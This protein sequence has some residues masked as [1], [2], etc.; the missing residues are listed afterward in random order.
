MLE[1]ATQK[2]MPSTLG[3]QQHLLTVAPSE[4]WLSLVSLM[5]KGMMVLEVMMETQTSVDVGLLWCQSQ[6]GNA[7]LM[8]EPNTSRLLSHG[9]PRERVDKQPTNVLLVLYIRDAKHSHSQP[10]YG[11]QE[12]KAPTSIPHCNQA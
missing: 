6:P 7:K 12:R 3:L 5:V 1:Y 11:L 9:V 4:L 8:L 10:I 2:D